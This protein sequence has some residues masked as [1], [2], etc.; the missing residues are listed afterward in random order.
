MDLSRAIRVLFDLSRGEQLRKLDVPDEILTSHDGIIVIG[1][2]DGH[3]LGANRSFITD[4]VR[5]KDFALKGNELSLVAEAEIR[6]PYMD[7]IPHPQAIYFSAEVRSLPVGN[8]K[9]SVKVDLHGEVY[10]KWKT[11][12]NIQ[13]PD[14]PPMTANFRVVR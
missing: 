9:F 14:F 8:Y 4:K 2:L 1:R 12:G 3:G 10:E 5:V 13:V 11:S 6:G 7:L